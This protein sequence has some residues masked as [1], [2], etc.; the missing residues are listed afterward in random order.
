MS[1]VVALLLVAASFAQQPAPPQDAEARARAIVA[2]LVAGAFAKIEA[3]YDEQMA[4]ALPRGALAT[5][6]RAST[7]Q[8]GPF[9]SVSSVQT[10]QAGANQVAMAACVFKNY[11]LNLRM[12]FNDKGQLAGL[13]SVAL[14]PRTNWTPPDYANPVSFEER[15]VTIR[16]G[17]FELPGILTLPKT[18]GTHPAVVLVHGSGPNDMDESLGPNK[19][20]KDLAYGLASRGVAV[21]RYEKRSH[22]Y[23]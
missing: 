8:L 12:V 19:T 6:W 2:A 4:K 17:R 5:S 11:S 7:A 14:T 23:G 21:L 22:K 3:Q 9:E 20:F 1:R 18:P 16:T 15:P 10:Q 13:A